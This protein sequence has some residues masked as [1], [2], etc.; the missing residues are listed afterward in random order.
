VPKK[1]GGFEPV[2]WPIAPCNQGMF[3]KRRDL[4]AMS[5][6]P[7]VLLLVCS[8]AVPAFAITGDP[9]A[10]SSDD[11]QSNGEIWAFSLGKRDHL[12]QWWNFLAAPENRNE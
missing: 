4:F 8:L 10:T 12:A 9:M 11:A 6:N 1:V 2:C 3:M 7:S 5:I